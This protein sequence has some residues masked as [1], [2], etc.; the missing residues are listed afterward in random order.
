MNGERLPQPLPKDSETFLPPASCKHRAGDEAL[1]KDQ[2]DDRERMVCAIGLDVHYELNVVA[3]ETGAYQPRLKPF[4]PRM[5]G[6]AC[7]YNYTGK[8]LPEGDHSTLCTDPIA[9]GRAISEA[10]PYDPAL[11]AKYDPRLVSKTV[12]IRDY[13]CKIPVELADTEKIAKAVLNH[14]PDQY[15]AFLG[16]FV[17]NLFGASM[18]KFLEAQ[19]A[20]LTRLLEEQTEINRTSWGA[21]RAV[22][23]G[24]D[25]AATK[26]DATTVGKALDADCTLSWTQ[27][28]DDALNK[29]ATDGRAMTGQCSAQDVY[30]LRP[31]LNQHIQT[32]TEMID[33]KCRA[34]GSKEKD[35]L[36]MLWYCNEKGRQLCADLQL[37]GDHGEPDYNRVQVHVPVNLYNISACTDINAIDDP[38]SDTFVRSELRAAA[39]PDGIGKT[40]TQVYSVGAWTG[41]ADVVS[42]YVGAT[43]PA[44]TPGVGATRPTS[45]WQSPAKTKKTPR[46]R[47]AYPISSSHPT[48]G[49]P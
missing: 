45:A 40:M 44:P 27:A 1:I 9:H 22:Q 19:R 39:N 3:Q 5:S 14:Y 13:G 43:A 41:T 36:A 6:P 48:F 2:A 42:T 20:G 46:T 17:S 8:F 49:T 32:Y 35:V 33:K 18:R 47:V 34:W 25:I 24:V 15:V 38:D 16:E 7:P 37:I 28:M 11:Y 10:K 23:G 12:V 29:L 4:N 26:D 31:C 30:D 21:Y